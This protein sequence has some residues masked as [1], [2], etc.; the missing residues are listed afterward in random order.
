MFEASSNSNV[1]NVRVFGAAK[2]V[3]SAFHFNLHV[4]RDPHVS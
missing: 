2:D 1:S 3:M 4:V